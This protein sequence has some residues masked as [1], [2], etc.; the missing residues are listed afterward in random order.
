MSRLVDEFGW[1]YGWMLGTGFIY[2]RYLLFAGSA[3]LFFY[4][5]GRRRWQRRKIQ[6]PLPP[7][8]QIRAELWHSLHTAGIFALVGLG[9]AFLQRQGWTKI[10]LEVD[11]FGWWYL[12]GSFF[13][14]VAIHDTYFYWMH[15]LLHHPLLFKYWHRVHHQSFNPTPLAAMAFHPLEAVAEIAI[16]PIA[17]VFI[18]FHPS[19]LLAMGM[20]SLTFNILGHLGYEVAPA[21]LLRHPLGR[22]LNTPTHHNLHHLKG[23]GNYGLYFNFW[24][25]LMGTNHPEYHR[26]FEEITQ[27]RTEKP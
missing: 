18:P 7:C 5:F 11:Q 1:G 9:I 14:L 25:T 8:Q 4:H 15:R 21:G 26:H 17:L 12:T 19:V 3:L 16:I 6:D 27:T 2:L 24:D 20:W 23:R 13:L 10:Y 22:W